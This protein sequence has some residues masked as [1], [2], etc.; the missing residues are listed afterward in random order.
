MK[1]V[2]N[3]K[4]NRHRARAGTDRASRGHSHFGVVLRRN[5][6]FQ[7]AGRTQ[8]PNFLS[9]LNDGVDYPAPAER[10]LCG[11]LSRSI[12][13]CQPAAKGRLRRWSLGQAVLTRVAPPKGHFEPI[14]LKNSALGCACGKLR[15]L[16]RCLRRRSPLG[17]RRTFNRGHRSAFSP[18]LGSQ[19]SFSPAFADI[20]RATGQSPRSLA[21]RFSNELGMN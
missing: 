7:P 20:A 1:N 16:F 2:S 13:S 18:L 6:N 17:G 21:R 14:L 3:D 10:Q 19:R 4:H 9:G 5:L 12:F 11:T 15:I 8:L